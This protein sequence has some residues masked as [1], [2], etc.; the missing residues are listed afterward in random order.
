MALLLLANLTVFCC[1][2]LGVFAACR[3][4]DLADGVIILR[5]WGSRPRVPRSSKCRDEPRG[6]MIEHDLEE[7][8]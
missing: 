7:L 5:F 6:A 4:S 3:E 2:V 8:S 1:R